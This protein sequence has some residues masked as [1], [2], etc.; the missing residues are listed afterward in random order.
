MFNSLEEHKIDNMST[1]YMSQQKIQ[2]VILQQF[3][4]TCYAMIDTIIKR[5]KIDGERERVYKSN[6]WKQ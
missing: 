1:H 6:P 3:S 2:K 4:N 5:R